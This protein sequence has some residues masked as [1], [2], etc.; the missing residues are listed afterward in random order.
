MKSKRYLIA[1]LASLLVTACGANKEADQTAV[2]EEKEHEENGQ[3][4]AESDDP[5]RWAPSAEA[6]EKAKHDDAQP[7]IRVGNLAQLKNDP[8]IGEMELLPPQPQPPKL[9]QGDEADQYGLSA[10]EQ[11]ARGELHVKRIQY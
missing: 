10:W 5:N 2:Q 9:I 7:E 11:M 8:A 6:T 4:V 3:A 1:I